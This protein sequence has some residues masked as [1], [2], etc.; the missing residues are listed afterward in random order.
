MKELSTTGRGIE[1]FRRQIRERL[2]RRVVGVIE[3]L[4]EEEVE[5]VLGC[6]SYERAEARRGYRHGTELRRVTTE[7]GT[8]EIRVPRARLFDG[9]ASQEFRSEIEPRYARRTGEVDE[10]IVGTYLSGANS[11]RI[12]KALGPLLGDEHLSKSAVSRVVG[13]V[14]RHFEQWQERDL[15]EESYVIVFLD[16]FHL[17]VRLA[18]RV[19]SVPVLAALGVAAGGR[20]W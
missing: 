7:V 5:Q 10:A 13:R 15:S 8:R 18:K 1:E 2:R 3:E 19:V 6:G 14:K 17:K 4:L 20:D 9:Q 16:A 11:R 12:R